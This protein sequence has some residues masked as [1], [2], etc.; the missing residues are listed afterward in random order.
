MWIIF[1][2]ARIKRELDDAMSNGMSEEDV[3]NSAR[4]FILRTFWEAGQSTHIY[5]ATQY[6]LKR[7]DLLV[8]IEYQSPRR[9]WTIHAVESKVRRRYLTVSDRRYVCSGVKQS[10]S[11]KANYR[12]LAISKEVYR[13]MYDEE[14]RKLKRD[15]R[16][17]LRNTGL[18]V[19]YKT[20]VDEVIR[21]GYHPGSWIQYYRDQD[22]ILKDLD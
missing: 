11:Y 6:N 16:G 19:C 15:C 14:W 12:W 17:T 18:L 20:K 4:K 13:D 2:R 8:F 9:Q 3:S 5:E 1:N 22:W 21:A 10:R 7:P